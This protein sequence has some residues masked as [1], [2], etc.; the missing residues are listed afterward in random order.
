MITTAP[1]TQVSGFLYSLTSCPTPVA[2]APSITK[3]TVKPRINMSECNRTVFNT[4]RS[5]DWSSSMLAPEIREM[6]PGTSGNTQGERKE[7]IPATKTP[8]GKGNED[9]FSQSY[10]M[11]DVLYCNLVT[12][13]PIAP[14]SPENQR[15]R[16]EKPPFRDRHGE[17]SS[18]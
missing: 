11:N 10:R 6:Y 15:A 2:T 13:F 14:S 17:F 8:I 4:L 12:D 9:M 3:T 7:T 18:G 16:G 1:A 5:F